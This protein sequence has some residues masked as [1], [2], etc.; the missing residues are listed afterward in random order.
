MVIVSRSVMW[1]NQCMFTFTNHPEN[2]E[3]M[4]CLPFPKG[5]FLTFGYPHSFCGSLPNFYRWSTD[6]PHT[7]GDFPQESWPTGIDIGTWRGLNW[8]FRSLGW[9][10]CIIWSH[11]FGLKFPCIAFTYALC[12]VGTSDLGTWQWQLF[13]N[14]LFIKLSG[15]RYIFQTPI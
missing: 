13:A 6:W 7:R 11:I 8:N 15:Y 12:V 5:C 4:V 2:H 14:D 3:W 1:V 9:R 10:F